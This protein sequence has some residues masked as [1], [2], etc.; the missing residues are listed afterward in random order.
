MRL[1]VGG[2]CNIQA[3]H[4]KSFGCQTKAFAMA[5]KALQ[6]NF[7]SGTPRVGGGATVRL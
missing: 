3:T 1:M 7:P 6:H 4:D 5:L 2:V